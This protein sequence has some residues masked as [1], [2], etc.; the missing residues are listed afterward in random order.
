[1]YNADRLDKSSTYEEVE[2][3]LRK[4]RRA[5]EQNLTSGL[6][7]LPVTVLRQQKIER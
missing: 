4:V 5:K 1:M 2:E 3:R 7:S 6:Y